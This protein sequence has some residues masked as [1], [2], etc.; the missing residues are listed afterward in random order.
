MPEPLHVLH[1]NR[2]RVLMGVHTLR[3]FLCLLLTTSTLKEIIS[4]YMLLRF[5]SL[6]LPPIPFFHLFKFAIV[7]Y[8]CVQK[9]GL[10]HC[11][12]ESIPMLP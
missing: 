5:G 12:L 2:G 9:L 4:P 11:A 8:P 6:Q 1:C 10:I 7:T 3:K